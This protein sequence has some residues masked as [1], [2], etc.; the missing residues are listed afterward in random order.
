MIHYQLLVTGE[1]PVYR[2]TGTQ[3]MRQREPTGEMETYTIAEVK[4][5]ALTEEA[6]RD[7]LTAVA[8]TIVRQVRVEAAYTP[9]IGLTS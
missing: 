3:Y 2:T 1:R 5:S 7:A 6:V 4:G 9:T 8:R